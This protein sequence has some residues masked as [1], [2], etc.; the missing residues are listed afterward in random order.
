MGAGDGGHGVR[1]SPP[2][3]PSLPQIGCFVP[4]TAAV[5]GL[6]DRIFT[7]IASTEASAQHAS[8][9]SLDLNQVS[10]MLRHATQ[11][12]LLL[13]DEFGKVWEGGRRGGLAGSVQNTAWRPHNV[14]PPPSPL[15]SL[16]GH[17]LHRR[18]L[19]ARGDGARHPRSPRA[20]AH[21]RH[22]TL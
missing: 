14:T 12:S 13:L 19:P 1:E 5:V 21:R 3:L 7:R 11:N 15:L 22:D 6:V 9:F 16:T 4:A 8:A 20:A 17:G 18:R 10:L 2:T